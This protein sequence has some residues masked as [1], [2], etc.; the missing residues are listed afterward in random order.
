M[1]AHTFLGS[2]SELPHREHRHIKSTV[3]DLQANLITPGLRIHR[4]RHATGPNFL[5]VRVNDDIRI[6]MHR[7]DSSVLLAYVDHHD[8]AYAWATRRR[9]NSHTI[10]NG[11]MLVFVEEVMELIARR[12][13]P[14][15]DS[16]IFTHLS[17]DDLLALGVS[18]DLLERVSQSTESEF[19]ELSELLPRQTVEALL[20][21]LSSTPPIASAT[22]YSPRYEASYEVKSRTTVRPRASIAPSRGSPGHKRKI[23]QADTRAI[24]IIETSSD[25]WSC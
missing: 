10:T 8:H 9:M 22:E 7:L 19:L 23:V 12:M 11:T 5:S 6:I 24:K 1:I 18:D 25:L 4:V 15:S 2:L 21:Q 13:K 20:D 14:I 17:L 3:F 16:R